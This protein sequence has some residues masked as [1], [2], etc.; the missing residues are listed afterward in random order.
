[1]VLCKCNLLFFFVTRRISCLSVLVILKGRCDADPSNRNGL[2]EGL[3][4]YK[5]G[6]MVI[7]NVALRYE[8]VPTPFQPALPASVNRQKYFYLL[9]NGPLRKHA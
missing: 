5:A 3:L 4:N 2:K 7:I 9:A 6:E 8:A 1:M